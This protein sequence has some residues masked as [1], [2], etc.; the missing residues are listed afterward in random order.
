MLIG[1]AFAS[2]PLSATA[3]P[4]PD[5]DFKWAT[6]GAAGNR[7][8]TPEEAPRLFPPYLDPSMAVGRVDHEYRIARTEMTVG[9]WHEFVQAYAPYYT[10]SP[11]ES[12]F[13]G[14]FITWNGREYVKEPGSDNYPTD[15]SWR[16][17][18]RYCNWLHNGKNLEQW[19]FESGAYDTSTFI[20]EPGGYFQ[21]QPKH[22]PDAKYW[23]PT[24]DEWIKATHYDPDRYG[25]G[26]EG[27]WLYPDGGDEPLIAGWPEQ[28]GE[29]TAGIELTSGF[30]FLE[31]G[32]YPDVQS[33]WGLL[34]A[35]GG[36]REWGEDDFGSR[37][38]R[39][40]LGSQAF[41]ADP[42]YPGTDQVDYFGASRPWF[43]G[44]TLRIASVVPAPSS[45]A[46]ITLLACLRRS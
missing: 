35:S 10:G 24:H 2:L 44:A 33:P 18:A 16:M 5:Y 25:P 13:T 39:A 42:V 1:L 28:G 9:Q 29:T 11:Y 15:M 41:E 14:F 34:D 3:E 21:D 23:I 7:P 8:V 22:S 12:A 32:S 46:L 17:A 36:W 20:T 6:I 26:Q 4:P 30:R 40:W 38:S 27:Y 45:L 37:W 43:A 31:V 19:A